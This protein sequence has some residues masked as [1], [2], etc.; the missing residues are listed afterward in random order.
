[1][2]TRET[3]RLANDINLREVAVSCDYCEQSKNFENKYYQ[4][5]LLFQCT[6]FSNFLNIWPVCNNIYLKAEVNQSTCNCLF[7]LSLDTLYLDPNTLNLSWH[8]KS[9]RRIVSTWKLSNYVLKSL[10]ILP[11][12]YKFRNEVL[13]WK[14]QRL[15]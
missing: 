5:F 6:R 1:M 7:F 3:Y 8:Y 12:W 14:I 13:H 11:P 10:M 4:E 2:Y 15:V 9:R